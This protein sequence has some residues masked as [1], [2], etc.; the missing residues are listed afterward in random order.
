MC[1]AGW[2]IIAVLGL[3]AVGAARGDDA[4]YMVVFSSESSP[5]RPRFCHTWVSYVRVVNDGPG[6]TFPRVASVHTISWL[7]ATLDVRVFAR[8]PEPGVNL[9]VDQTMAFA[10]AQGQSVDVWAPMR[11]S[12]DLYARS[13]AQWGR[14]QRREPLYQ[15]IDP[16]GDDVYD[17]I[18]ANTAI[19]PVFGQGHYPLIYVG[20]AAGEH[21]VRQV[22]LRGRYFDPRE[23]TTWMLPA[24]GLGR[25]PVRVIRPSVAITAHPAPVHAR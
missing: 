9:D 8:D 20:K 25:Y 14:L 5:K 6:P 22:G 17:C 18:H 24:L 23:D 4:Y 10:L 1:R 7:P 15:A 19:D 11:I 3:V 2:S 21:I 16:Y 13:L 12:P